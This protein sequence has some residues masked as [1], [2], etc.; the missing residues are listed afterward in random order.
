MERND[1][2]RQRLGAQR[3]GAQQFGAQQFGAATRDQHTRESRRLEHATL[4]ARMAYMT[5]RAAEIAVGAI[6]TSACWLLGEMMANSQDYRAHC[7]KVVKRIV[8]LA[9]AESRC[10]IP[11][12]YR[13]FSLGERLVVEGEREHCTGKLWLNSGAN[14]LAETRD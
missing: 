8:G 7:D 1:L 6:E 5:V 4:H 11:H 3:F 13:E 10:H 9:A 14:I 12:F 2:E